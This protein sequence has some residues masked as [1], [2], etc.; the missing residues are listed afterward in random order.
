MFLVQ[1][2]KPPNLYRK[3]CGVAADAWGSVAVSSTCHATLGQEY[4]TN[5]ADFAVWM[6]LEQLSALLQALLQDLRLHTGQSTCVRQHHADD[7]LTCRKG[8]W[9]TN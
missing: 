6:H 5:L 2:E 1:A 8:L 3:V 7:P 4:Y 9:R